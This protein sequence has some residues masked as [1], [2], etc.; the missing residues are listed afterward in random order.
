MEERSVRAHGWAW[1]LGT[2]REGPGREEVEVWMVG[3]EGATLRLEELQSGPCVVVKSR[4]PSEGI[5]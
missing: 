4:G 3:K 2:R 5:L 1:G